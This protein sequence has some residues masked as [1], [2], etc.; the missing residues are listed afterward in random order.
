MGNGE[1]KEGLLT[2]EK[3]LLVQLEQYPVALEQACNEHNPSVIAN[4]V[5]QLAQTFNSFYTEHSV[6]NAETEEKKKLRVQLAM[7]TA[8]VLKSGMQ[9]LGIKV[10]ERM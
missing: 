10:P 4:Y 8:N 6:A 2:L 1:W 3:S 5:F 9:L 7:M